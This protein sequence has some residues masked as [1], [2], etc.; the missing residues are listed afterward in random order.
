MESETVYVA[1]G[2]ASTGRAGT[3]YGLVLIPEDQV[4]KAVNVVNTVKERFGGTSRSSL[5]CRELFYGDARSKSDWRHLDAGGPAALC[6]AVFSAIAE[7][8][9]CYVLGCMPVDSYPTS[10]RLK[11]KAGSGYEDTVHP[12]DDKWRELFVYQRVALL[13]DPAV[14]NPPPNPLEVVT[15]PNRP[16]WRLEGNLIEPAFKVSKVFL[17]REKTKIQWFSKQVQ[18]AVLARELVVRGP[19]GSSFLPV[20]DSDIADKHPLLDV[21]DLFVWNLARAMAGQAIVMDMQV[22]DVHTVLCNGNAGEICMGG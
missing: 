22:Q 2:D 20:D 16:H 5:H 1:F 8:Q 6:G 12:V 4:E 7:L 13:L 14:I 15:P 10:F 11:A 17:D 3:F 21:A 19:R 18:W 9:P